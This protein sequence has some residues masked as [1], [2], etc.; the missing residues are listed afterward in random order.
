MKREGWTWRDNEHA[1]MSGLCEG[2]Q[3]RECARVHRCRLNSEMMSLDARRQNC[4]GGCYKV[5][6]EVVEVKGKR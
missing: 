5:R 3:H 6:V 4:F 2:A 1:C